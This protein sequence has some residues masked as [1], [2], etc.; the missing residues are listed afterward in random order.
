MTRGTC[1]PLPPSSSLP[2]DG[3]FS[4]RDL[5]GSPRL[6]PFA[7][8]V[9]DADRLHVD[10]SRSCL[11]AS[12]SCDEG[13]WTCFRPV[14][15][16][17]SSLK[18]D[19]RRG[20]HFV[21]FV[22]SACSGSGESFSSRGSARNPPMEDL[23]LNVRRTRGFLELGSPGKEDANATR[24]V[25]WRGRGT[26]RAEGR[27]PG[28]LNVLHR[29]A[30]A[31]PGINNRRARCTIHKALRLRNKNGRE[32]VSH[33]Q[34]FPTKAIRVQSP[35]GSPDFRMWESCRT[36]PL[37][38]GF[39]RG[40]LLSP[41]FHS[42]ATPYSPQSPSSA[43]KTSLLKAAQISS[44]THSLVSEE[45]WAAPNIEVVRADEGEASNAG[46]KGHGKREI[47]CKNP[48]TSGIVRHNSHM[49]NSGGDP[50]G[51]RTRFVSAG[52]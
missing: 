44:L 38:G 47:P 48:P 31:A 34:T 21:V 40:S 6:R 28:R 37:V 15:A 27:C 51:N 36:M 49:R 3:S 24:F 4:S 32:S 1:A 43:L 11:P 19:E 9:A 29:P 8:A 10:K 25:R 52:G 13:S 5:L 23:A 18:E 35:A 39:S 20:R 46:M 42:A 30:L 26:V 12:G 45:I 14:P 2:H 22:S 41:P 33:R 17:Q 50:A 7:E 16:K